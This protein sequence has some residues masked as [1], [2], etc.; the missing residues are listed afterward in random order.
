[1]PEKE[2]AFWYAFINWIQRYQ[3]EFGYATLA[4]LFS[5][6]RNACGKSSWSR[7]LFDA[8]S[9]SALAFFVKPLLSL[10]EDIFTWSLPTAAPEVLAV[11][12][13]YVGTD[14]IRERIKAF[15]RH[16]DLK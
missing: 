13:G 4:A 12:I 8:L 10:V 9:C 3:T 7:R 15:T 11:Y 5:F 14:Y 16:R 2:P 6:L 1:M